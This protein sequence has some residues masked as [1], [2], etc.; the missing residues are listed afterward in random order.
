MSP[1]DQASFLLNCFADIRETNSLFIQGISEE[2]LFI[3]V[4][5]M[6]TWPSPPMATSPSLRTVRIVVPC[7]GP[8]EQAGPVSERCHALE[9]L[10]FYGMIRITAAM[11][12]RHREIGA[13]ATRM[14]FVSFMSLKIQN[15][16]LPPDP[17]NSQITFRAITFQ[18]RFLLIIASCNVATN[19][20]LSGIFKR[21]PY[22][23]THMGELFAMIVERAVGFFVSSRSDL[24][25][26]PVASLLNSQWQSSRAH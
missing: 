3:M 6:E 19:A 23:T 2:L 12:M 17:T 21:H 5:P 14:R 11:Q 13:A 4:W 9:G 1:S 15:E 8:G 10:R 22:R 20:R 25:S 26:H 16:A 24:P 7:R 18:S